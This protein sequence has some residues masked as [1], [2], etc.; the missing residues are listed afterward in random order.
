MASLEKNDELDKLSDVY[1]IL[2]QDAKAI[3][4]DLK[5]GVVM[6]REAAAGAAAST[7]FVL[8]L[9]L[10]AFRFYPPVSIEGWAYVIGSAAV[11]VVM[12]IISGIG[13]RKY[14]QLKKKY[15]PLFERA[16]KL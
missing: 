15:S 13:F 16:E 7:G 1:A 10:T 11:A 6:W 14:F 2:R 8:I 3:I 9:I 4:L 12:A 5:G